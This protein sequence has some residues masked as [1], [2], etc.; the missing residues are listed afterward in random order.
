[1]ALFSLVKQNKTVMHDVQRIQCCVDVST[2]QKRQVIFEKMFIPVVFKPMHQ[3]AQIKFHKKAHFQGF[4]KTN[5][6][7][8][9]SPGNEAFKKM[10]R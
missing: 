6:M 2:H 8:L 7:A 10:K 5:Q 1:M 3:T 9:F 4:F